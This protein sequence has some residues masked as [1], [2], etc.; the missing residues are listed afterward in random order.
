[1]KIKRNL[2]FTYLAGILSCLVS[3]FA[4][5]D[6]VQLYGYLSWRVEKVWDELS[7]GD[8]GQTAKN[9]APREISI[10]SFNL[11]MQSRLDDKTKVFI[12]INGAGAEQLDLRNVWGEYKFN[13]KLNV[14][15]G[16]TY[17][18]FGLYNE[19][20]DAVP[21]YIGIE[22][23]ELFDKDHLIIS[24]ETLMMV[25]GSTPIGDGDFRYS[26]S[27]DN[28]E[29]GP[30]AEDN[31]PIGFD[32]RYEWNLGQYIAGLSGYT[33]NGDTTSDVAVGEGSPSTGVLPWMAADDFSVLGFYGQFYVGNWNLQAAFWNASH[34]ATRDIGSVLT[35]VDNA[36]INSA[37]RSRFLIDPNLPATPANIDTNGDYDIETWYLRAGYTITRG[38]KEFV[39]YAQWDFY[40]NPE[41]IQSKTFG[42]DNEAGLA[43][44]GEFTKATIGLIYRPSPELAVKFDF[45]NHFQEFNGSSE[46]YP[47][48]RFDVSYIFGQ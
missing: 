13:S 25:H 29:G 40:S 47:E 5:A 6:D 42:G 39:P 36:G 48:I 3:L 21:T 37:Q 33:S 10:P 9:D 27:I 12:N 46:S 23:P 43:D 19:I 4:S 15:I 26:F 31:I 44:D 20:L 18:R 35:V 24:R 11:M 8:G 28:G 41:T 7:Y 17:R 45:S 2:Y 32:F 30:T 34:S 1:M 16:K 14:R 38:D 22:P